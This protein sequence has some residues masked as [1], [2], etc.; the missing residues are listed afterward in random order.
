MLGQ[1]PLG[2][3]MLGDVTDPTG[4]DLDDNGLFYGGYPDTVVVWAVA[5]APGDS[6]VFDPTT[7]STG[8]ALR[9]WEVTTTAAYDATYGYGPQTQTITGPNYIPVS[10]ITVSDSTTAPVLQLYQFVSPGTGPANPPNALNQ[11]SWIGIVVPGG[12][13]EAAQIVAGIKI[14][15]A[16]NSL[17]WGL[18]D[19]PGD[20][21]FAAPS[22]GL[23]TI[24]FPAFD[25]SASW[26]GTVT[27]STVTGRTTTTTSTTN[28]TN[29]G[30]FPSL[31]HYPVSGYTLTSQNATTR[32]WTKGSDS[33]TY[34]LS[35][36]LSVGDLYT[37]F[38]AN[39]L[40]RTGTTLQSGLNPAYVMKFII[41][42]M[43]LAGTEDAGKVYSMV[44]K[45]GGGN[46]SGTSNPV[47]YEYVSS[48]G[49]LVWIGSD[50]TWGVDTV[51]TPSGTDTAHYAT[52]GTLEITKTGYIILAVGHWTNPLGPN[53]DIGESYEF[54]LVMAN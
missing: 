3:I 19:P 39:Y 49:K 10:P 8:L 42:Q 4:E 27:T 13:G 36:L 31:Q 53:V 54:D 41:G 16:D 37:R 34:T 48:T 38:A 17:G 30:S 32:V 18:F 35:D 7:L 12:S 20:F 29:Y 9:Y 47:T 21:S 44:L 33:I 5:G 1:L 40:A 45:Q 11:V 51:T 50:G 25:G 2:P 6:Q 22:I 14:S 24:A 15:G 52:G 26:Y 43:L 46:S 23:T 28:P